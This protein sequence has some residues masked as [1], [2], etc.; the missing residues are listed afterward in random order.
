MSSNGALRDTE[1]TTTSTNNN[2]T[3]DIRDMSDN[4]DFPGR[5]TLVHVMAERIANGVSLKQ[6]AFQN[7]MTEDQVGRLISEIATRTPENGTEQT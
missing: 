1:K 7:N 5:T 2:E 3:N 4:K 6:V